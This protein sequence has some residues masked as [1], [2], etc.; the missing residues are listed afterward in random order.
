MSRRPNVPIR[1]IPAE[2]HPPVAHHAR[3][4]KVWESIRDWDHRSRG[5]LAGYLQAASAIARKNQVRPGVAVRLR[6][7]DDHARDQRSRNQDDC[8]TWVLTTGRHC[9]D[10]DVGKVALSE[11]SRAQVSTAAIQAVQVIR[12][13]RKQISLF[14]GLFSALRKGARLGYAS[15]NTED[16]VAH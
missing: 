6:S 12:L 5:I 11:L 10:P 16:F 4:R 15:G 9:D 14:V 13:T 2:L 3:L 1:R 7:G 8:A